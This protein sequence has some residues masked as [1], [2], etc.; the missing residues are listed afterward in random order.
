MQSL[1]NN[2][3]MNGQKQLPEVFYKKKGLKIWQNS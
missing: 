2:Y 3:I 1:L